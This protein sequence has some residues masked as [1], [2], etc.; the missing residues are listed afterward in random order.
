MI[1]TE[2][3]SYF[4]ADTGMLASYRAIGTLK[5]APGHIVPTCLTSLFL[6][7]SG[8]STDTRIKSVISMFLYAA[9]VDNIN[10]VVAEIFKFLVVTLI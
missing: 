2:S 10:N 8:L 7:I 1:N 9:S 4:F 6:M 3:H 5:H